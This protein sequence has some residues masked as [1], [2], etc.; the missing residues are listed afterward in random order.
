MIVTFGAVQT[1][2][3]DIARDKNVLYFFQKGGDI[4]CNL[5]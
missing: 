2:M 1:E 4:E 3:V 5:K